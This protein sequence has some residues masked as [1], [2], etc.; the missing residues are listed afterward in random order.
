MPL[1]EIHVS[2]FP[3]VSSLPILMTRANNIFA[4]ANLD[5]VI[6]F[7][8]SSSEM[9]RGLLEGSIDVAHAAPDNF[10]EWRDHDG[11]P[12]VSWIGGDGGPVSLVGVNAVGSV[13]DLAGKQI[14]VDAIASGYVSIL[15]EILR[16]GGVDER[17]VELVPI[18]ETKT[19]YDALTTGQTS[20]TMLTLPWSA[21][22]EDDGLHVLADQYI[23]L[24][25]LQTSCGASTT[26]W[27]SANSSTADAYYR[28]LAANLTWLRVPEHVEAIDRFISEQYKLPG[29]HAQAVRRALLD[30]H[31]GWAPSAMISQSGFEALLDLRRRNGRPAA[32]AAREYISLEPYVRVFGFG[33]LD[34]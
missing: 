19:R 21:L 17:D 34:L 11:V 28:C 30:P 3:G 13:A 4:H 2:L 12:I 32:L 23:V 31:R 7:A 33:L 22:A 9:K 29:R 8:K 18:G 16:A 1:N 14:A 15:R 20:A 26:S 25:D 24:P 10:V 5:V 6:E 27:L